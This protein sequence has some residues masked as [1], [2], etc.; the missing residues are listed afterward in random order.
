MAGPPTRN[1]NAVR[2]RSVTVPPAAQPRRPS[3]EHPPSVACAPNVGSSM[4]GAGLV[5]ARP[6]TGP[7]SH[8]P[9]ERG[10][11]WGDGTTRGEQMGHATV[12][13]SPADPALA[14]ALAGTL[15]L[16]LSMG[17]AAY[18]DDP[19]NT[20]WPLLG[21]TGEMQHHADLSQI[22]TDTVGGGQGPLRG[23]RL[24]CLPRSCRRRRL[25][26]AGPAR[27][28]ASGRGVPAGRPRRRRRG[29]RHAGRELGDE[30][31]AA[32]RAYLV[33]LAWDAHEAQDGAAGDR[34][35]H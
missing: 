2:A 35:T 4:K 7:R 22:N 8:A 15:A 30:A 1:A 32:L 24:R 12:I 27:A 28:A 17:H 11:E 34:A 3:T 20:D 14:R 10:K 23:V 21:N 18:A 16:L 5:L 9:R 33:N 29:A 25:G 19:Q 31:A 26:D 6:G 13:G